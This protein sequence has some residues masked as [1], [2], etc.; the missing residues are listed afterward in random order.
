MTLELRNLTKRPIPSRPLLSA[1]TKK[2][3]GK[4]YTLSLVICADALTQKL[5]RVYR[6]K[7]SPANVL[8]FSY[9]KNSGEIFLN[10]AKAQRE[11]K[12]EGVSTNSRLLLLFVHALAHL[13][14]FSHGTA[15]DRFEKKL[16]GKLSI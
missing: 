1:L 8:S 16:G 2:A 6:Q 4:R 5:N 15:M 10:V 12:K 13:R 14:G 7:N 3:L 9:A 11:A